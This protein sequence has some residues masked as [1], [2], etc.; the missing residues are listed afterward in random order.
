MCDVVYFMIFFQ[1]QQA[2]WIS[3][4][5]A[6]LMDP[7]LFLTRLVHFSLKIDTHL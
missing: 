6:E 1:E 5:K 3:M 2:L 7:S 4:F